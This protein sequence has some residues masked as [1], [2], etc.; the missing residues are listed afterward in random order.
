MANPK[1]IALYLPQFH[2]IPENDEF[3]GKGFTD[4]TTV[5]NAKPIFDRKYVFQVSE[6]LD[7]EAMKKGIAY[8]EGKHDFKAFTAKKNTKKSTVRTIYE[9]K[10]EQVEEE[11]IFTF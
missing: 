4:W 2:C 8:L 5:K 9:I 10:M 7:L 6:K 3:W 1:I 11:L